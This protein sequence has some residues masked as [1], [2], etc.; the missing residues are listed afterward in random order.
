M[1]DQVIFR[2][3]TLSAYQSSAKTAGTFYAT[4]DTNQ[5]FIGSDE[6]TKGVEA[7]A[8]EPTADQTGEYGK[9]Y[10]YNGTLYGVIDKS[11][12]LIVKLANVSTTEGTVTS[13]GAGS[14]L[15]T[16]GDNPITASGTISHAVPTGAAATTDSL[17]D[18]TP[19]FGESF[20]VVGVAT[21]EFGHVTGVTTHTVTLPEETEVSVE[22]A[23]GTPTTLSAGDTFTVVTEV[24]KGAAD[25]SVKRTVSTFTLPDDNNTEYTI[26]ST[27]AGKITVTPGGTSTEAAY[28][29]AINGWE[30]LA[31]KEDIAKVFTYLGT[32]E[33]VADLPTKYQVGTTAELRVGDVYHVTEDGSEY[34]VI[35][36]PTESTDAVWEL[37]GTIIDL[38]AYAKTEDVIARVSSATAG[39]VPSL[40]ADGQIT[41]S[42]KVLEQSIT[43]DVVL[44]TAESATTT[45]FGY[46]SAADKVK[47]DAISDDEYKNKLDGVKVDGIA[48][49][50]ADDK[51]VDIALSNFGITVSASDINDVVNKLSTSG[52]TIT[53]DL[54]VEG[55]L[56]ATADKATADADGNVIADT[57]ALKTDLEWKSIE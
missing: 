30:N 49:T 46:M 14:G 53:G 17:K 22:T 41:D 18:E 20:N 33:K 29:V 6:Y 11:T 12:N 10:A 50:I 37:L 47:L 25:Q 54:T 24:E 1:A 7:L 42:G 39:N 15:T 3:G 36:A 57:Y 16:D 19:D 28:D 32:V 2:R 51:T 40:T 43:S 31:T 55:E 35:T 45:Q 34:V 13:V 21:D 38:S 44:V 27:S 5:I 4:S 56:H 8:A 23:T 48:L 26:A 9:L 52:G